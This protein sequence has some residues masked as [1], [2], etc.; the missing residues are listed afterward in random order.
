MLAPFILNV[1][2]A[3][4]LL[5]APFILDL[6]IASLPSLLDG[7]AGDARRQDPRIQLEGRM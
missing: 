6:L 7:T 3:L 5:L 2:V 4:L 1:L